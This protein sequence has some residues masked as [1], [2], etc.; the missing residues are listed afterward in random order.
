ME[1]KPPRPAPPTRLYSQE[2]PPRPPEPSAVQQSQPAPVVPSGNP[3]R[4]SSNP[5][6][7]EPVQPL[8][9]DTYMHGTIDDRTY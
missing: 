3:F 2:A 6:R 5:F 1:S 7:Q 8:A 9:Q 4:S